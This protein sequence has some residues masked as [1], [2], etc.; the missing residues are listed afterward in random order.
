MR[1]K[2]T[3]KFERAKILMHDNSVDCFVSGTAAIRN[4]H[5]MCEL[6]A[7]LQT[8]Q[9]IENINFLIAEEN[10][11]LNNCKKTV[12]LHLNSIRVYIKYPKDYQAVKTVID[13]AWPGLN[14]IYLLADI[15][16]PELLV[17]IEGTAS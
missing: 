9:T 14:A 2:S 7:V 10:L 5:S 8:R 6:D 1:K 3:P 4:E 17:E 12:D 15:C 16:R 11:L 13:D